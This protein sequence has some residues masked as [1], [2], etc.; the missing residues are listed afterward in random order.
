[1]RRDK[2]KPDEKQQ[3]SPDE[4]RSRLI[5]DVELE[6]LPPPEWLIQDI[7]PKG[8][9]GVLYSQPACGKSFLALDWALCVGTGQDWLGKAVGRGLA[10]F[11][12]AEGIGGLGL[13]VKAWKHHREFVGSAN[14]YFRRDAVNF[15]SQAELEKFLSDLNSLPSLP[16]LVV[17]DTM[18]RCMLGGDENSAMAVG[19][20]IAGVDRIRRDTGASVLVIHHTTK[21]AEGGKGFIERGSSALRGAADTMMYVTGDKK[22]A[23]GLRCDKMKDALPFPNIDFGLKLIQLP[24]GATS[25]VVVDMLDAMGLGMEFGDTTKPTKPV[26][27]NKNYQ[28]ALE[29]L[30]SKFTREGATATEWRKETG[31]AEKTFYRAREQLEKQMLIAKNGDGQGAKYVVIDAGQKALSLSPDCQTTVATVP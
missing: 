17:I 10:V 23:L 25:C 16:A 12:A 27:K 19:E 18:A 6:A 24:N 4:S 28:K 13:R 31:L 26:L 20:F 29:V 8:G 15:L 9:F 2:P 14:C 1:M 30:A 21:K 3:T 7:L 5:T 22:D 11:V